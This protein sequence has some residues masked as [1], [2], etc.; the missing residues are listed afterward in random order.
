MQR[1][2]EPPAPTVGPPLGLSL[3]L[4]HPHPPLPLGCGWPAHQ[5]NHN[6]SPNPNHKQ[7][8]PDALLGALPLPAPPAKSSPT[9]SSDSANNNSSS[10]RNRKSSS[11]PQQ[12]SPPPQ[13]TRAHTVLNLIGAGASAAA[14]ADSSPAFLELFPMRPLY[15]QLTPTPPLAATGGNFVFASGQ[16]LQSSDG[17]AFNFEPAHAA[18][19]CASYSSPFHLSSGALLLFAELHNFVVLNF[20]CLLN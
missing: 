9:G 12:P 19:S 20:H 14:N 6:P 8:L 7:L 5:P 1:G 17:F 10:S 18:F 3:P 4:P 11:L 13:T 2:R 16:Q 15:P